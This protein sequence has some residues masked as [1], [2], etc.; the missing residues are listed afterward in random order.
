MAL[1]FWGQGYSMPSQSLSPSYRPAA[2]ILDQVS[3]TSYIAPRVGG[4]WD[5]SMLEAIKADIEAVF[6]RDPA[7]KSRLEI[8]LCY[9]SVHALVL[10]RLAHAAWEQG[11]LLLGRWLSHL[12]RFLTGIEIHPRARIGKG[13]FIDHGMGVVIGETAEIGDRVTLYHG[14]TL[15]GLLPS[16]NAQ[17]Q[18]G[19]KRH[20]T[21]RDDVIVGSGAQILGPVTVDRGARIGANAVVT[22]DVPEGVTM[23]GIP[24]RAVRGPATVSAGAGED[25]GFAPYGITPDLP[26]PV[27]RAI[28]GLLDR[29]HTL[30]ARVGELERQAAGRGEGLREGS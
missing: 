8:L 15:G 17:A 30:G 29:V 22:K 23:V 27:A 19:R 24:A 11:W 6:E 12:G 4:S 26:D 13:V 3:R 5:V 14:V 16:V 28:D 18:A 7:V 21:L 2:T 10:Y 20:P 1:G 25:R 9:P